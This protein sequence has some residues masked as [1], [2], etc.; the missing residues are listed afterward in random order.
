[1]AVVRSPTYYMVRATAITLFFQ[2]IP[3]SKY[4]LMLFLMLFSADFH[5]VNSNVCL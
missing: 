3:L 1:M 5:W 2:S 4:A